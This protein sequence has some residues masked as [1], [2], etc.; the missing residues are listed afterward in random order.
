[1]R[2]DLRWWTCLV[3]GQVFLQYKAFSFDY[4]VIKFFPGGK[5]TL[6]TSVEV[7]KG[8]KL[9]KIPHYVKSI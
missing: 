9:L 5:I 1:M 7:F 2:I 3:N 4:K 8:T 6:P